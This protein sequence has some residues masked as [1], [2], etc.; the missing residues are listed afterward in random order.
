AS[1]ARVD[2]LVNGMIEP[3]VLNARNPGVWTGSGTNTY[4]LVSNGVGLLVDAGVGH[5]DHLADIA[6]ALALRGAILETLVV[7]HRHSDHAS[8]AAA[9]AAAFPGVKL[10][11]YA[12]GN[13]GGK[14][15]LEW[16]GLRD[17]QTVTVG[18]ID[19]VAIH[20]PGH[21]PDHLSFWHEASRTVFTGD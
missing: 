5:E 20:T 7:T 16:R 10:A 4:L 21:S 18:E 2:S 8:G 3:I 11:R 6:R 13:D 15:D 9:I 1:S 12:G 14:D 17:K 19:L